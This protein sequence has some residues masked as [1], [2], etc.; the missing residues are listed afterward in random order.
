MLLCC[1]FMCAAIKKLKARPYDEWMLNAGDARSMQPHWCKTEKLLIV[2]LSVGLDTL[3]LYHKSS[4]YWLL[5]LSNI[6]T[7]VNLLFVMDA[8]INLQWLCVALAQW[9]QCRAPLCRQSSTSSN[10][11]TETWTSPT[12]APSPCFLSLRQELRVQIKLLHLHTETEERFSA[13]LTDGA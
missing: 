10:T 11:G 7:F 9:L 4:F 2:D 13:S 6:Y 1:L 3:K 12:A 8:A 5:Q